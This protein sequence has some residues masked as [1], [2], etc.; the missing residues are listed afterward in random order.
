MFV[1]GSVGWTFFKY[2]VVHYT[3]PLA[4]L[5]YARFDVLTA[6]TI[7]II[8]FWDVGPCRLVEVTDVSEERQ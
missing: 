4:L 6:M 7:K 1:L 5:L 3:G 2:K 8:I